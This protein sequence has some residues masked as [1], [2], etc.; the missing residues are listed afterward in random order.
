M[1]LE[2]LVKLLF[3]EDNQATIQIPNT[4]NPTLRHVS[5]THRVNVPWSCE[6]CK[7]P[8]E[9]ELAHCKTDATAADLCTKALTHPIKWQAL[10]DMIGTKTYST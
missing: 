2:R 4:E 9:A 5:R 10:L 7:N 8:K 6:E 3:Q 1:V